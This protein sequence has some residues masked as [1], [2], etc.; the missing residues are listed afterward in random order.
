MQAGIDLYMKQHGDKVAGKKIVLIK[1][2]TGGPNPDVAKRLAQ[3]LVVRDHV[4]IL[5]GFTLTPEALGA[6]AVA[7]PGEEVHG[8][9]E[10][11]NFSRHR[12]IALYRA[13]LADMPQLNYPFGKWAHEHRASS[14][15][16]RSSPIT[17]P[18][19]TPKSSFAKGFKE[20][21]GEIVGAD[22]SPVANPDFSA[23]VQRIKDAKSGGGVRLHSGRRAASGTRQGARP[24]GLTP[25]DTKFL[26]QG[27]LTFPE[28]LEEHGPECQWH[29]HR[30][31]LHDGT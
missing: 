27:E 2:D 21:G 5:A 25:P 12:K 23:Y 1:K 26:G 8:R 17:A 29:H 16:I 9:H 22:H 4:D 28:A 30:L 24:S 3:E 11:G 20:T 13:H 19:M 6:A 15:P 10:R 31:P 18:A 14:M 7:D